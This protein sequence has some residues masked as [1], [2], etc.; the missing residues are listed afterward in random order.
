MPPKCSVQATPQQPMLLLG[1]QTSFV[2]R[3][4][5]VD[6]LLRHMFAS[7]LLSL[8]PT[9]LSWLNNLCELSCYE[10][11]HHVGVLCSR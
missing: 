5:V 3:R 1:V 7:L 2:E 11:E 9:F 4:F 8:G 10:A 6:P